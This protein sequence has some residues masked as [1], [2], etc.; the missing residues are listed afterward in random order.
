M[1]SKPPLGVSPHWFVY[2]KRITELYEAIGR[3]IAHIEQNRHIENHTQHYKVI[4]QWAKEIEVLSLLL[5]EIEK[6]GE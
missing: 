1:V 3:Y 6:K 5:A 2:V 4:A